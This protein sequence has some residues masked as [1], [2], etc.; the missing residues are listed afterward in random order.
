MKRVASH[1]LFAGAV[2]LLVKKP[3]TEAELYRLLACHRRSVSTILVAL[4]EEGLVV[5]AEA[6]RPADHKGPTPAL[7]QWVGGMHQ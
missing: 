6:E 3:R 7:W 5:K 2:M 4:A 1:S